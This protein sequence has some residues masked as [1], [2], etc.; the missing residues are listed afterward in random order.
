MADTLEPPDPGVAETESA[1]QCDVQ[2]LEPEPSS[3][4]PPHSLLLRRLTRIMTSSSSGG[5]AGEETDADSESMELALL[6]VELTKIAAHEGI[7]IPAA[8]SPS[9]TTAAS[10]G[11]SSI[12]QQLST[13]VVSPARHGSKAKTMQPGSVLQLVQQQ[14]KFLD[15]LQCMIDKSVDS[16]PPA[17]QHHPNRHSKHSISSSTA[18]VQGQRAVS[19]T[20]TTAA[21]GGG[22]S[23]AAGVHATGAGQGGAVASVVVP[24]D[25][26]EQ[27]QQHLSV[28][29]VQYEQQLADNHALKKRCLKVQKA[30]LKHMQAARAQAAAAEEAAEEARRYVCWGGWLGLCASCV[31]TSLWQWAGLLSDQS[32][33]LWP[34]QPC[35]SA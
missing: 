18:A 10:A 8:A 25:A 27:Q 23:S 32:A 12:A 15:V 5:A 28:L 16:R 29:Q 4:K 7:H 13:S 6:D 34:G 17:H 33:W 9:T 30:M 20:G 22:T 2:C 14:S 3:Q 35:I 31:W 21:A 1:Q 19:A 24:A 11:G 26:T